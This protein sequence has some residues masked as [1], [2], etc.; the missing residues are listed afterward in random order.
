MLRQIWQVRGKIDTAKTEIQRKA[1]AEAAINQS[2][3][4][5]FINK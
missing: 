4:H 5:F 1:K 2:I 3:N